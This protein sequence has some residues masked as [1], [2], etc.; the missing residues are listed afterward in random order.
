MT[1]R[2]QPCFDRFISGI[3]TALLVTAALT[4][5]AG[6]VALVTTIIAAWSG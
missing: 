4:A 1:N 6:C 5:G 3:G 2:K